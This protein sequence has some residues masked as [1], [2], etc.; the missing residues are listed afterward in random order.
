[1]MSMIEK[2][3]KSVL[4]SLYQP[5]GFSIILSVLFM[6]FYLYTKEHGLKVVL[7]KWWSALKIDVLF[8]RILFLTFYTTMILFRTLLN[9]NIWE[10][11]VSDVLGGWGLYNSKGELTTEAIENFILFVRF[12]VL[13]LWTFKN[14]LL[15]KQ[16]SFKWVLLRST[17]VVFLFSLIIEVLQLLLRLGT[18]QLS[19]LFYN[20][21]GG[22]LG[23]F[24]YWCGC[25]VN[26]KEDKDY[27]E[28]KIE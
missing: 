20:T 16:K 24:I 21:L 9:R 1:M 25:H 13:L 7:H 27:D 3:M 28:L 23:G 14:Y 18:F 4:T 5:L 8:R 2:I 15:K 12:T 19:D 6:F 22:F 11:P 17:K 26:K 10:N